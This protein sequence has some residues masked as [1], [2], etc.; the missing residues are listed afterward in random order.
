MVTQSHQARVDRRSFLLGMTLNELAFLLF[1]LLVLLSTHLLKARSAQIAQK[2]VRLEQLENQLS[3]KQAVL[4]KTFK[5]LGLLQD[6]VDRLQELQPHALPEEL[7]E[8]FKRLVDSENQARTDTLNLQNRLDELTALLQTTDLLQQTGLSDS[9]VEAVQQLIAENKE[10]EAQKR[11]L[12]AQIKS[13]RN[14][15]KG[16]GLDHLP[17]WIDPKTG[18]IEYLFRITILENFLQIDPAWPVSRTAVLKKLP[19]VHALAKRRVSTA[20]FSRRAKPILI[21]SQQQ[22]PECRHFVRIHDH[23]STSKKAFK[24]QLLTVEGY[25]YKYL[26]PDAPNGS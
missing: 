15:F 7:D 12:E 24:K 4:D 20:E 25:F 9:P 10:I 18:A 21:W 26:E 14:R 19:S 5:K 11:N 2:S 1:F 6:T 22:K 16:S 17:C 23:K 3:Q 13:I 8:Q